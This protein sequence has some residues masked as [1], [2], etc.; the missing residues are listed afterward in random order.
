MITGTS[1]S[2][3]LTLPF[4][5]PFF[6]AEFTSKDA[7]PQEDSAEISPTE[8]KIVDF[9]GGGRE[10]PL[11]SPIPLLNLFEPSRTISNLRSKN[12]CREF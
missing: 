4:R 7:T 11:F 10:L 5:T 12:L 1:L 2:L 6:Y 8:R 9:G 3:P